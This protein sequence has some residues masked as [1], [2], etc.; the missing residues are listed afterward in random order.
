MHRC[1]AAIPSRISLAKRCCS[2]ARPIRRGYGLRLARAALEAADVALMSDDLAK[3]PWLVRHARRTV[4][5]IQ[6]NVAFALSV[7]VLFVVLTLAGLGSLWAAIA[8]DMGAS[9]LVTLNA[10]RLLT[11]G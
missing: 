7:K 5:T 8:A 10:L 6:A 3:L 9:L 2:E 1:S 11:D 4:A